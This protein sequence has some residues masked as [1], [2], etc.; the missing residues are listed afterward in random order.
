MSD[1]PQPFPAPRRGSGAVFGLVVGLFAGVLVAAL[2]VPDRQDVDVV[3][4]A[5]DDR[6]GGRAGGVSAG[7]ANAPADSATGV[8]AGEG[9]T[10]AP[11]AAAP[12][13]AG[14]AQA[15]GGAAPTESYIGDGMP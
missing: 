1:T 12:G 14:G 6:A 13:S 2:I 15:A 7:D 3:P 10:A 4:G 9:S 8:T 11:G 5:F